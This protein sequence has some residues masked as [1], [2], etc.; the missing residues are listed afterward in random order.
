MAHGF[1][2]SMDEISA[3][4]ISII[5][6]KQGYT[7]TI[8]GSSVSVTNQTGD[9]VVVDVVDGVYTIIGNGK[10]VNRKSSNSAMKHIKVSLDTITKKRLSACY[11]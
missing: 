6:D 1:G 5:M 9:H 2:I 11:D 10:E 8:T 7:T 4:D 3:N